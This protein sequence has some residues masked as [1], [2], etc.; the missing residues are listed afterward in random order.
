MLFHINWPQLPQDSKKGQFLAGFL[1]GIMK[2]ARAIGILCKINHIHGTLYD[3]FNR[4]DAYLLF[5]IQQADSIL[6]QFLSGD[7]FIV[8]D[9]F[10]GFIDESRNHHTNA[11]YCA[12]AKKLEHL[13]LHQCKCPVTFAF[14]DPSKKIRTT[15]ALR[16]KAEYSGTGLDKDDSLDDE[17]IIESDDELADKPKKIK[18]AIHLKSTKIPLGKN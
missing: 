11:E 2:F 3:D 8:I 6:K 17:F 1:D 9:W 7:D 14:V 13:L 12:L 4:C 16:Y 18:P 5:D 15:I 10:W